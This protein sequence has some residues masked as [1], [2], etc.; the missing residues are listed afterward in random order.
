MTQTKTICIVSAYSVSTTDL[1]LI[2]I[3]NTF[4]E[5]VFYTIG[6]VL[7]FPDDGRFFNV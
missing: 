4:T 1:F 5:M 3:F 2:F 6:V 7:W